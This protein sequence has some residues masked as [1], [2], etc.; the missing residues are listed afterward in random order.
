MPSRPITLINRSKLPI[1]W[2]SR[3]I[4]I[5][6]RSSTMIQILNSGIIKDKMKKK[7]IR[8]MSWITIINS[9]NTLGTISLNNL[10]LSINN[11]F[12]R[13]NNLREKR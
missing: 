11:R 5:S 3:Q 7:T 13:N 1:A 10:M 2:I 12:P 6:Y 9:S 8:T 4:M